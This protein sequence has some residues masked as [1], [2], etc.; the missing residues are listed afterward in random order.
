MEGKENWNHC[1]GHSDSPL[2]LA[3]DG[4]KTLHMRC[5]SFKVC[6]SSYAVESHA[7]KKPHPSEAWHTSFSK[8]YQI[9]TIYNV[10]YKVKYWLQQQPQYSYI[11]AYFPSSYYLVFSFNFTGNFGLWSFFGSECDN[12]FGLLPQ[13]GSSTTSSAAGTSQY[14]W[15]GTFQ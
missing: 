9:Y 3:R 1:Q 6:L 11:E 8:K 15:T 4:N 7:K 10:I 14:G 2:I 13:C 12:K 5:F